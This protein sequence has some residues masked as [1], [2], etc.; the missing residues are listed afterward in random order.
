MDWID[1]LLGVTV[2]V[3]VVAVFVPLERLAPIHEQA[4][5]RRNWYHDLSFWVLNRPVMYAGGGLM[6]AGAL[7]LSRQVIPEAVITRIGALPLWIGVPLAILVADLIF[8]TVHR[9]SH[10]FPVMWQF[11]AVHHSIRDLDWLAGVRAH[12]V[13]QL[14]TTVTGAPARSGVFAALTAAAVSELPIG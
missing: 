10:T 3:M 2:F 12:P 1:R 4:V 9:A 6:I 8:Y 5:F 14:M 13:D 11:H 7:F